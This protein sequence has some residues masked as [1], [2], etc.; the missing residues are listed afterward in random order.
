MTNTV[1]PIDKI[2]RVWSERKED[3]I[4]VRVQ[5]TIAEQDDCRIFSIL[6]REEWI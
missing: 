1:D 3:Q 4:A 6:N 2:Y 5:Y